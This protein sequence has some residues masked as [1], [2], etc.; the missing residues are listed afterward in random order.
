MER[1]LDIGGYGDK[2]RLNGGRIV[3]Q[4]TDGTTTFVSVGDVAVLMFSEP[5]LSVSVAV[6]SELA[7]SGGTAVACDRAHTS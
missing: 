1:I 4:R 7:K 6:L 3:I 5:C 2:V